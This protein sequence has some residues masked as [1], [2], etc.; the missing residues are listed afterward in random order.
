[1]R[2]FLSFA[3]PFLVFVLGECSKQ[4]VFRKNKQK[5]L[6]NHVIETKQ[7]EFEFECGLLCARHESC[8]S[9][10]YKTSG[11]DKGRCELNYKTAKARTDD[12]E[13]TNYEF[14]HLVIIKPIETSSTQNQQNFTCATLREKYPSLPD[15]TYYINPQ[16]SSSPPFPIF[17]DMT[18]KNGVGV[19]VISHDS[20]ARTY[21]SGI[22]PH[23]GYVKN[24]TYEITLEQVVAIINHSKNCEQF[25][26]YECH[27]AFILYKSHSWWVSRQ[28]KKM[29]YWGGAAV[30]SGKC[31]CGMNN[32]CVGG[33]ICN[34]AANEYVLHEDS[35]FL[36]DRNTLPVSQLR[37][38]DTGDTEEY[39]FHTLGKMLCWGHDGV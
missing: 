36:S 2:I 14:N 15:G 12:E 17:C 37:F 13:E 30:D 34:C 24:V 18:S 11:A 25:I 4:V 16:N 10:N 19:T 39:G 3:V 32:S 26:K 33:G 38:G 29:N 7:A 27:R 1:M 31:A 5:Y 35:G 28:G 20:E 21:V 8:A 6:A 9:I 22:E 23:G